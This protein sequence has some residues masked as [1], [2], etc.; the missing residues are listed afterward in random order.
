M[1]RESEA[2]E[3][4]AI[5]ALGYLA[6]EPDRLSRF[7]ALSGM[8]PHELRAHAADPAFLG[9][10]LD[11]LLEDEAALL[12]FAAAAGIKPEAVAR[13]RHAL[14]GAPPPDW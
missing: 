9:G 8:A 3:L 4:L 5:R 2:A 14:P 1:A 13:A 6:D 10:V 7:V 12:D 11:F